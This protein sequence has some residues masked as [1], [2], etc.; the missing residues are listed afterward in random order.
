LVPIPRTYRVYSRRTPYSSHPDH[1]PTP[2][3][4]LS[5]HDALPIYSAAAALRRRLHQHRLRALH[6]PAVR[7]LEPAL[8]PMA[9]TEAGMWHPHSGA[10]HLTVSGYTSRMTRTA[11]VVTL[12]A[13]LALAIV[14]SGPAIRSA[15]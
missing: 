9:R 13:L 6:R 10:A 11:Q 5:L 15:A 1:P 2:L 8:G 4:T 3:S 12:T 14:F 7:S